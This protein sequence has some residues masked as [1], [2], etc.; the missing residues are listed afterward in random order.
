MTKLQKQLSRKVGDREYTKYVT[1]IPQKIIE[2]SGLKD[3]DNLDI[4]LSKGKI[5]IEKLSK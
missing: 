2:D 5:V 1:V 4:R 3:G